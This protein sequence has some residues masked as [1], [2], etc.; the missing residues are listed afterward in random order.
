MNE[1]LEQLNRFRKLKDRVGASKISSFSVELYFDP[2]N[3]DVI[4][5]FGTYDIGDCPRHDNLC[6]TQE[7][8]LKD[9]TKRI[10]K[11]EDIITVSNIIL[12][13]ED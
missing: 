10:D 13:D 3:D 9:I 5:T 2:D 11:Y 7:N 4:V 1:L 12:Q 6:T 8:L